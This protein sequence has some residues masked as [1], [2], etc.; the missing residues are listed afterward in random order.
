MARRVR[1]RQSGQAAAPATGAADVLSL[2]DPRARS[3]QLTGAKAA[4]LAI[5]MANGMPVLPGAVL[6]TR[7][8]NTASLRSAWHV[9]SEDGRVAVAV[10]SSSTVEDQAASSMAGYF[11]TVLDVT[12]WPAAVDAIAAVKASGT[13][14]PMAV[15]VQPMC[16]AVAG[17]VLFGVDP[18]SGDDH[19]VVEVVRGGPRALVSG[20]VN[21]ASVTLSHHG[22]VLDRRGDAPLT[23]SQYR[24]LAALARDARR[25]FDGPQDIEWAIDRGGRVWLLQTRPV[26]AVTATATGPRFGPG[27]VAETFP[28]AL[29]PLE[30]DLWV[31][32]LRAAIRSALR[33][34]GTRPRRQLEGSSIVVDIGGRVAADLDVLEGPA[35]RRFSFVDP[36]PGARRLAAAWRVGRLRRALPLLADDV[37]AQVDAELSS[38]PRLDAIDEHHL[39]ALLGQ[40]RLLL[41]AVH[42][43][44][45]L[46]GALLDED[47]PT[48]ISVAMRAVARGR[49]D[50]RSDVE[51]AAR[52]PESLALVAPRIGAAPTFP[53]VPAPTSV[54]DAPLGGREALR[55]RARWLHELTARVALELGVRLAARGRLLDPLTIR[56]LRLDEIVAM[57]ESG[58]PAPDSL[59]AR[60]ATD[61]PAPLP[62]VFRLGSD[63]RVVPVASNDGDGQGAGGGRGMGVV[64]A[65]DDDQPGTVLVV[66][67]LEPGL[68]AR[69]AGRAGLVA[70]TGS[71]LAHLAIVA[72]ELGVPTVVGVPDALDRFPVGTKVVV[73]GH[74]GTV[75]VV[76]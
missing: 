49:V 70:E 52:S 66:R 16:D 40:C 8:V 22:R 26:T 38:V 41:R 44:E 4:A 27:P 55:L 63:D 32:P 2:D 13:G 67:T 28:D 65:I 62:A 61:A 73:D 37:V 23:A 47:G 21:A 12:A 45:V 43:H 46:A 29:T 39:L 35:K 9:L 36:R 53:H 60:I 72:R 1:D 25:I 68:A 5:A 20:D 7:A 34:T 69:L 3:A 54:D 56:W 50:G 18:V 6:T 15:L 30:V 17:G 11:T 75:E 58:A 74:A 33:L 64:A 59:V 10:R 19:L 42:A 48:G 31:D 76:Q 14:A 71:V 24:Q 57:V 51:I